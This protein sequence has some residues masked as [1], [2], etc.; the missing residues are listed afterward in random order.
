MAVVFKSNREP[1]TGAA[2]DRVAICVSAACLAQCLL[3]PVLVVVTPLISV[4]FLADSHFH[5]F[6]LLVIVPVSLA[7]FA[8]GYRAHRNTRMLVPGLIGL[9]LVLAAAILEVTVIDHLA[10]ALLTS[11]GGVFL[12]AGHWINLRQRRTVC[13]QPQR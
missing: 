10:A 2:L 11:L 4:G 3:L 5:L 9:S 7:A 8:L 13:M 1:K 12:I 6:L